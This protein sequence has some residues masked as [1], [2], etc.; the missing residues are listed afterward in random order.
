MLPARPNFFRSLAVALVG[1]FIWHYINITRGSLPAIQATPWLAGIDPMSAH[2]LAYSGSIFQHYIIREWKVEN[3][4]FN[5]SKVFRRGS[6][7]VLF[8]WDVALPAWGI[9]VSANIAVSLFTF[10]I[11][12][13]I[14]LVGSWWAQEAATGAAEDVWSA[15]FRRDALPHGTA[16]MPR[17]TIGKTEKTKGRGILTIGGKK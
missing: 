4:L 15:L 2:L 1:G 11:A 17:F 13:L 7:I 16:T 10:A 8:L 3:S 5:R 9:L 6:A 14:E 12:V